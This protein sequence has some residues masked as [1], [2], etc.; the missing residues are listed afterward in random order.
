MFSFFIPARLASQRLPQKMLTLVEGRPLILWTYERALGLERW[1]SVCVLTDSSEIADV[2]LSV[3]G[4]VKM[5]ESCSSGTDRII[6]ILPQ[7]DS[8]WVVNIQG[9]EPLFSLQS[10]RFLL[11]LCQ[12]TDADIC[13]LAHPISF[14]EAEN[15]SKVKVVLNERGE[16]LYFSRSRIPFSYTPQKNDYL[17]HIGIYAYRRS[18]LEVISLFSPSSISQLEKLEQLSFLYYG[19]SIKIGVVEQASLGIDTEEDLNQL[20]KLIREQ[21]YFEV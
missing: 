19:L 2:I 9:D 21:G 18:A 13:S 20:K 10:V 11:D 6:S 14:Y 5:T 15:T 1:G 16:A 12:T 4:K 17:G 7:I 8:E 3:G